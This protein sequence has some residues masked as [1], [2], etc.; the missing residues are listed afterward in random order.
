MGNLEQGRKSSK[1]RGRS[2]EVGS[3]TVLQVNQSLWEESK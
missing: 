2:K 1:I 3:R